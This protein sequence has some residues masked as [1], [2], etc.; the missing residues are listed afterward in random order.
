MS[1][2]YICMQHAA[3]LREEIRFNTTMIDCIV[4]NTLFKLRHLY[5]VI[6]ITNAVLHCLGLLL[7]CAFDTVA[8]HGMKQI[9][10]CWKWV[11]MLRS[12]C[13]R[14]ATVTQ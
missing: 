2:F 1:Q 12:K 4:G 10:C 7:I 8:N 3:A 11:E 5:V 9:E 6:L 13:R 14:S